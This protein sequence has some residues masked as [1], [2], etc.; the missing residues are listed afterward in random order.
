MK[1]L[2]VIQLVSLIL[3]VSTLISAC[4]LPTAELDS[5]D[6]ALLELATETPFSFTTEGGDGEG[7]EDLGDEENE[8]CPD[9]KF[10]ISVDHVFDFSPG[11]ATDQILVNGN[12]LPGMSC[13]FGLRTAE[14]QPGK[15]RISYSNDGYYQTDSDKCTLTGQSTAELEVDA[16]CEGGNYVLEITEIQEAD[17]ALG[18]ILDCPTVQKT[19]PNVTFYPPSLDTF[20]FSTELEEYTATAP[21]PDPSGSFEYAKR[22]DIKVIIEAPCEAI[23]TL[24]RYA[25]DARKRMEFYEEFA[26]EA[27]SASDLDHRVQDAMDEYYKDA[28]DAGDVKDVGSPQ[29]AGHFDPCGDATVNVYPFCAS[30]EFGYPLCEWLE[31]GARAHEN[32][33]QSD[34][35]NNASDTWTYCNTEGGD[36]VRI[37]SEWEVN[38]YGDMLRIYNEILDIM[39]DLFPECF[40]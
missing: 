29:S 13:T 36:E 9:A 17:A 32:R 18:G 1:K 3:L 8:S 4:N 22:W 12:T 10:H 39:R 27:T 31:E 38:A 16:S 15:C 37:T 23:Q 2:T 35:T 20:S 14:D 30:G 33:H 21:G 25:E 34:A 19:F 40:E 26:N 24:Q 28:I 7:E 11:R 6:D 5:K